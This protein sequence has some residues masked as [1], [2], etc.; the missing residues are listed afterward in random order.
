M[1]VEGTMTCES[2]NVIY[3]EAEQR[4]AELSIRERVKVEEERRVLGGGG[5][6]QT[7]RR[8][9]AGDVAR[10]GCT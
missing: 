9:C 7:A 8:T 10:S 4:Q 3:S 2:N 5:L 6:Q 1:I